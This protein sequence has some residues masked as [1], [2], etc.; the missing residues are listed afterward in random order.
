VRS[1]TETKLQN[2]KRISRI[3]HAVCKGLLVLVVLLFLAAVI[4]VLVGGNVTIAAFDLRIAVASLALPARLLIVAL[5]LLS[6]GV[7]AKGLYHLCRLFNGYA[8]GEIFTRQAAAQIRQL[9][10]TVILWACVGVFLPLAAAGLMHAHPLSPFPLHIDSA[11]IGI[12]II[13]ISWFME[14]AAEMREEN[15]LTI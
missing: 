11:L 3:L 5:L 12:V 10:I 8:S 6:M 7:I 2:I 9:G 1:E 14:A 15:E 4:G 13:V